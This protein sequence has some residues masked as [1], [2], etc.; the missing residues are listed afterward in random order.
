MRFKSF[1]VSVW[2]ALIIRGKST[3]K[4]KGTAIVIKKNRGYPKIFPIFANCFF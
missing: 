1:G 3:K 2:F 4:S